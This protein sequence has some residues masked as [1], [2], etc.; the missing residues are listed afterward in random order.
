[1]RCVIKSAG[2]IMSL[3]MILGA[4]VFF[5]N[6]GGAQERIYK[7][8]ERGPGGG[9][10]FYDKGNSDGG[11]RY[12]EAAPDELTTREGAE[13][14]CYKKEIADAKGTAIGTGKSNTQAILKS[15]GEAG[16]AARLCAEYRGGG[17]EDW[18]LPSRDEL[19]L[20]YKNLHLKRI[21][22]FNKVITFYWS[23][24]EFKLD[25]ARFEC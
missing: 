2:M 10:I 15:C 21:G 13:W 14:G 5:A 8:G 3:A 24:S 18:F 23:S 7:I 9:W 4:A 20:M 22:D 16:I 19:H 12:L 25:W 1:M 17:K 6:T 11:W